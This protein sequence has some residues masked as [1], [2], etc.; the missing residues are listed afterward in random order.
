M[1]RATPTTKLAPGLHSQRTDPA[2]S[3]PAEPADRCRGGSLGPVE[4]ALRDHVGDHWG[5]DGAGADGV[6]A[7][8]AGRV[9][10]GGARRQP[11]HSMLEA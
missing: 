1:G 2:I 4:F 7:D 11:D 9:L 6:D 5:F 8:P 10:Q 3:E